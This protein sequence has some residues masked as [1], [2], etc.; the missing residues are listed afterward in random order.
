MD[1]KKVVD[2]IQKLLN[3][4]NSDNENEAKAAAAA[5]N[6]LLTKFNLSM[7]DCT[8]RKYEENVFAERSRL[9][10]HD[11]WIL[12]LLRDFYFVFPLVAT[13]TVG[14]TSTGKLK[15]VRII[16]VLGEETNVEIARY[17][18]DFFQSEFELLWKNFA[19]KHG[20][21]AK[22]KDSYFHGLVWGIKEQLKVAQSQAQTETGLMIV[23][24]GDLDK[25][26]NELHPNIK[27][28]VRSSSIH[29]KEAQTAGI[30]AGKNMQIRKGLRD[31]N[32]APTMSGLIGS[33]LG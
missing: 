18:F 14:L 25:Y 21:G 9:R 22:S 16:K 7:Q 17:M 20:V 15:R 31:N 1:K 5:A 32:Q 12:P 23:K 3:L 10:Q 27:T 30:E 29:D 4:A 8:N 24:D 2:R 19:K 6:K 11:K 33:L 13:R 28:T 26:I